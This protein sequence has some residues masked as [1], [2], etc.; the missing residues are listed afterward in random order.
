MSQVPAAVR[1]DSVRPGGLNPADPVFGAGGLLSRAHPGFELRPGQIRMSRAVAAA[2]AESHHLIMEAPTG[3]GKTFA[4]LVPAI[5]AGRRVV[6]STGTRNLQDQLIRKDIPMLAKALGRPIEA[7][8]LKGRDNY[9]CLHRLREVEGSPR[10]ESMRDGELLPVIA[11]W[12]RTTPAGERGE[13][14]DLPDPLP[15]WERINA[16]ADTCLGQRCSDYEDCFLTRIRRAAAAAAIVVV[17]HH[18]LMADLVLKEHAFGQVIPEYDILILDEAHALEEAATAHLGRSISARQVAELADDLERLGEDPALR[19]LAEGVRQEGRAFFGRFTAPGSGESQRGRFR[20]APHREDPA[21]GESALALSEAIALCESHLRGTGSPAPDEPSVA[22]LA[23]RAVSHKSTLALLAGRSA[24]AG[25][26]RSHG[27]GM[28]LWGETRGRGVVLH[29]SPVDLSGPLR[30]VLFSRTETVVLTSATLSVDGSFDFIRGRLGVDEA[31]ELILDSPFDVAAQSILFVPEGMPE[32]RDPAF[33]EHVVARTRQLLDVTSGRAFL[34]FTS[35]ANLRAC[36]AALEGTI[37]WPL[38]VQGDASRHALLT[39][40][41]ET[42]NAVLLATSSFWHGVDVQGEALSL[43]VIDK[44]P[45][46]VPSDPVVSARID[47]IR[48]SGGSPFREYQIP[49][50]IIDLKQGL[51][52]L[53]RSRKDRGVLAVLDGRLLNRPY[54]KTFLRSLPHYRLVHDIAAVQD[55]FAAR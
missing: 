26:E 17:N 6:I 8:C 7:V 38:L 31:A 50:A 51:G 20:L 29:A 28:V 3:T 19:R 40:F 14:N 9:L 21:F 41:R 10:F 18:L 12:S 30:R 33:V 2:I 25:E 39:R 23:S 27:D 32:P 15:L 43:V 24:E 36:R 35:Y 11:A 37:A 52:R 54:G 47:S 5:D 4:Y 48:E 13:L 46:D 1:D 42:P 44:L 34:L 49:S 53:I 45:F 22:A 55:F 16:R